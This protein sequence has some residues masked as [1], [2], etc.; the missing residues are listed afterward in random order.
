MSWRNRLQPGSFRKVPYHTETASGT[1]GRRVA[2]HQYPKQEEH[3][4]EDMGGAAKN[5]TLE[6]YCIG[7]NYD[8]EKAALIKALDTPGPG[9][10]VHP[11]L[12][13]F[14]IQVSTY[15]WNISSRQGGFCKIS[16]QYHRVGKRQ[17]PT[18]SQQNS[19]QLARCCDIAASD[20]QATFADKFSLLKQPQF[21]V[22]A[23][24]DQLSNV[25][26]MLA[27]LNNTGSLLNPLSNLADQMN[28]FTNQLGQL[29]ALPATLGSQLQG[30]VSGLFSSVSA[31]GDSF[32]VYQSLTTE[33]ASTPITA[34]NT[35]SRRTQAANQQAISELTQGIATVEAVRK[36][37]DRNVTF[38]TYNEAI[39][40]RDLALTQLDKLI[41]NSTGDYFALANLQTAIIRRIDELAP[42]LQKVDQLTLAQSVPAL[43]LSHQLY[44]D[45]NRANEMIS[46]NQINHP[47][48]MP[49]GV[50]LEV[51]L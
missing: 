15:T 23:A 6:L 20:M 49:A 38:T 35:A 5:D 1:G 9:T 51:L 25:T 19:Q 28:Q 7:A 43:V 18:D 37:S 3:W 21:V 39:N 31:V 33:V 12:G 44:Q 36:I 30:L 40:S 16:V 4:P 22:Q 27:S 14:E 32:G 46:R 29:V 26:N 2:L 41:E 11:Y 34:I 45:A 17:F 48:F 50:E 8:L 24:I 42:G 47:G 10:L 13:T